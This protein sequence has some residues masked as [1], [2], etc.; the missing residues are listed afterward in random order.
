MEA[1]T[2]QFISS[3]NLLNTLTSRLGHLIGVL[4]QSHFSFIHHHYKIPT[5]SSFVAQN[6]WAWVWIVLRKIAILMLTRI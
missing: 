6:L 3:Q 5:Y 2:T 1:T 4:V